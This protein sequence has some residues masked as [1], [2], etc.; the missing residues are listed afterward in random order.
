M[1]RKASCS[2]PKEPLMAK[3][4]LSLASFH[5]DTGM[6]IV[7][8]ACMHISYIMY[9]DQKFSTQGRAKQHHYWGGGGSNILRLIANHGSRYQAHELLLL[10]HQ[11]QMLD[12][13]T[14]Q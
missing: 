13:P 12:N 11:A 14:L 7:I 4:R 3:K 10:N 2:V 1:L 9:G 5:L 6:Y 8:T